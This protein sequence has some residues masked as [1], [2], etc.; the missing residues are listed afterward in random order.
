MGIKNI[1][2]LFPYPRPEETEES[3]PSIPVGATLFV[4]EPVNA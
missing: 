4:D 3:V 1:E 2:V